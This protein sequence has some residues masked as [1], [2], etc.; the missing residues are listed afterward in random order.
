M[1]I[2]FGIRSPSGSQLLVCENRSYLFSTSA[3]NKESKTTVVVD[4]ECKGVRTECKEVL[5]REGLEEEQEGTGEDSSM[6][7]SQPPLG[8][9][10]GRGRGRRKRFRNHI[11]NEQ[12]IEIT[13]EIR[14]KPAPN[15]QCSLVAEET[16]F[17]SRCETPIR[18]RKMRGIHDLVEPSTHPRRSVRP[19]EKSVQVRKNLLAKEGSLSMSISDGELGNCNA[20]FRITES[21]GND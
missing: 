15:L 14:M 5:A 3:G 21:G 9:K 12:V 19:S 13:E 1:R 17:G 16:S 2:W 18:R 11:F 7:K 10:G 20:R 4:D 8:T 6:E